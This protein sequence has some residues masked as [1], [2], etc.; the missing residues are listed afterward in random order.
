MALALQ[1]VPEHRPQR[2][3][4]LDDEDLGGQR[5]Q[6]G[7]T[8]ARRA[9]S[10]MSAICL[11]DFSISAVTRA[12][13]AIAFW[14]S[15]AI[16]ARWNGSSRPAKSADSALMLRL[17]RVAERLVAAD[18]FPRG[19]DAA[20]PELLVFR[21]PGSVAS[22]LHLGRLGE[23]PGFAA[24]P[25]LAVSAGLGASPPEHR[26]QLL[27]VLVGVG[28]RRRRRG[29]TAFLL[30]SWPGRRGTARRPGTATASSAAASRPL[31]SFMDLSPSVS[32]V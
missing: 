2:V 25:A 22:A 13:S 26:R 6:P 5:S 31:R 32:I 16:F 18:V 4:V 23:S 27:Q 29:L 14:R 8:P 9:S 10:S 15:S 12:S 7:G 3:L 21:G 30:P 19:G 20:A 1:R 28:L 11:V 24:S 17:Q